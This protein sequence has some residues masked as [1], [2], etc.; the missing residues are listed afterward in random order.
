MRFS[1][2]LFKSSITK[3][4]SAR[5]TVKVVCLAIDTFERDVMVSQTDSEGGEKSW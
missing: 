2:G 5:L 4:S 1:S 3:F